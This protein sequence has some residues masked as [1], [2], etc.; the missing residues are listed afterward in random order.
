MFLTVLTLGIY[1]A[2]AKVR[3]LRYFYGHTW[4]A[5]SNFEYHGQPIAILKGRLIA[6]ALF[7]I[8]W[9]ASHFIPR[10]GTAILLILMLVAPWFIARSLMFNARSSS[11]RNIRFGFRAEYLDVLK[12]IWPVLLVPISILLLPEIDYEQ[13]KAS[14][15]DLWIAFIPSLVFAA[16]YPYVFGS[17][18][19]LHVGRSRYGKTPFFIDVE[20]SSFYLIWVQAL[21]IFIVALMSIP[22]MMIPALFVPFLGP[23]IL[24]VLYMFVWSAIVAYTKAHTANLVFHS[25]GLGPRLTFGS[26]LSAWKLARIYFVNAVAIIFTL[27]LLIPWAVI[28][29]AR[30]RAEQLKLASDGPLEDHL[31]E[32][33][34][35]V[36]ATGEELGE[37]FDVDL[38]L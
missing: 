9:A 18:K 35:D 11:Y 10:L 30:Y 31:A 26:T 16:V 37:M 19:R 21:G 7:S 33:S 28:R 2:W 15:S 1:S 23:L 34:R 32:M 12:A 29:V 22:A 20:I 6:A 24:F 25:S 36:A 13:T 3:R 8:Y 4:V 17:L 27:G 5:G 14:A 38:S